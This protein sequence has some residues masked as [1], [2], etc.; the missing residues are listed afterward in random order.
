MGYRAGV[1]QPIKLVL[2]TIEK[3]TAI[4][5]NVATELKVQDLL[6]MIRAAAPG[7]K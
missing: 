7:A 4:R 3:L 1:M 6:Q 5:D 2:D